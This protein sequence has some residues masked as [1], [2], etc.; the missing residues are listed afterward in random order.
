M[1]DA[2]RRRAWA[3]ELAPKLERAP[4]REGGLPA[5]RSESPPRLVRPP[6]QAT[7]LPREA[8]VSASVSASPP[9][10]RPPLSGALP[11]GGPSPGGQLLF[12]L[13]AAE[14]SRAIRSSWRPFSP[15]L[16]L[17]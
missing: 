13:C 5:C 1:L 6:G 8:A 16:A 10:F 2:G 12:L 4:P 15:W 7:A 11:P 9:A 17:T 3:P 14:L